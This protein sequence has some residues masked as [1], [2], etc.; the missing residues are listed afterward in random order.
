M[1]TDSVHRATNLGQQKSPPKGNM[2]RMSGVV[3]KALHANAISVKT[4]DGKEHSYEVR[5]L[6]Q[7]RLAKISTGEAVVLLVDDENKVTD[8]SF[9]PSTRKK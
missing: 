8:V 4:E 9:V 6:I 5:P 7:E 1:G 3:S 2:S